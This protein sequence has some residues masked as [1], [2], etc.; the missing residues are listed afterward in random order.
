MEKLGMG[1]EVHCQMLEIG[2]ERLGNFQKR[3]TDD[4]PV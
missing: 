1:K 2:Q 4:P 3:G